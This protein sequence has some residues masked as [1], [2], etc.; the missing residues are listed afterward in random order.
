MFLLSE[1]FEQYGTQVYRGQWP[2]ILEG[3]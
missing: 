3:L 2:E 1:D